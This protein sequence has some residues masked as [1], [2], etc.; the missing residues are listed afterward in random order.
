MVS[1]SLAAVRNGTTVCRDCQVPSS[2]SYSFSFNGKGVKPMKIYRQL[3]ERYGESW[4]D[5]KNVRNQYGEF[6]AS[7]MDVHDEERSGRPSIPNK[8]FAKVEPNHV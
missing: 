2:R 8:T 7:R 1:F 4:I 6:T 3:A 5:A